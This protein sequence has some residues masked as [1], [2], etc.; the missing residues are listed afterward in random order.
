MTKLSLALLPVLLILAFDTTAD[1]YRNKNGIQTGSSTTDSSG[2]TI[3]RNKN[4]IQIGSSATDSSGRTTYRDKNG[5]KIGS[6][7]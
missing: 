1:I 6:K 3:Y 4:G 2:R 7:Q 5:I